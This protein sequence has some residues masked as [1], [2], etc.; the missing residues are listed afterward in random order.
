[1]PA[2]ARWLWEIPACPLGFL[3]QLVAALAPALASRSQSSTGRAET[4]GGTPLAAA[5]GA[6][7]IPR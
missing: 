7:Q 2:P 3:G 5:A 6:A 4:L 1:M